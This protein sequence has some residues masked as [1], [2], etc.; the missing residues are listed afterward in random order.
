ML[1]D[2]A[3]VAEVVVT[4]LSQPDGGV[5]GC[6]EPD[7]VVEDEGHAALDEHFNQLDELDS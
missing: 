5:K 7:V 2:T 1:A 3:S 4:A 6:N